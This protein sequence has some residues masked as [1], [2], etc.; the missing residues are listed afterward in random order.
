MYL[1]KPRGEGPPAEGPR[2]GRPTALGHRRRLGAW[3][4]DRLGWGHIRILYKAPT[5]YSKPRQAIQS[6]KTLHKDITYYTFDVRY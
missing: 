1:M 5:E 6:P 4:R 3:G 2:G